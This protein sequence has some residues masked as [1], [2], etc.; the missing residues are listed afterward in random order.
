MLVLASRVGAGDGVAS[1]QG[2]GALVGTTSSFARG[3]SGDGSV[4]I[5]IATGSG[6]AFRWSAATGM[7]VLSPPKGFTAAVPDG[8]STDGSI[9]VGRAAQTTAGP[10]L[11]CKWVGGT[12]ISLGAAGSVPPGPTSSFAFDVS[13]N[14]LVVVGTSTTNF[15]SVSHR[16]FR[17][18][19]GQTPIAFGTLSGSPCE[20][21]LANAVTPDGA[22]IVGGNSV[23][24]ASAAQAFRR[25]DATLMVGLGVPPGANSSDAF[26]VSD[27]GNVI[28]CSCQVVGLG[29]YRWINGTGW[30][31]V[32]GIPPGVTFASIG[33]GCMSADGS[34]IVGIATTPS[35]STF[36]FI[37]DA[38]HGLRNLY[39]VLTSECGLDLGDWVLNASSLDFPSV[40]DDGRTISG[41]GRPTPTSPQ[42]AWVAHMGQPP[43]DSDA[44]GLLDSWETEGQGMDVNG[45]GTIDLDLYAL[46]ARPDRKD[47]FVEIDCLEGQTPTSLTP[48]VN[49]FANAP[50]INPGGPAGINLHLQIDDTDLP[51]STAW[52]LQNS[53]DIQVN[54]KDLWFG[55]AAQRTHPNTINILEAKRRV[56]RYCTYSH[57]SD[58]SYGGVAFVDNFIVAKFHHE[59]VPEHERATF[60]HELGHSLGLGHGGG[61]GINHKPNYISVMNYLYSLP[62]NAGDAWRLDYS[63]GSMGP[64]IENNIDESTMLA[65]L[66]GGNIGVLTYYGLAVCPATPCDAVQATS[67]T[68]RGYLIGAGPKDFNEDG[69]ITAG[70]CI[71]LN[72]FGSKSGLPDATVPSPCEV[73]N[74]HNDWM[75]L[76]YALDYQGSGAVAGGPPPDPPL[77]LT[78]AQIQQLH[79]I[80]PGPPCLP[81]INGSRSVD[82]DDLIAVILNWGACPQP[83]GICVGD[84]APMPV[85]GVVDVDDLIAVILAWGSCP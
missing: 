52:T 36:V 67:I 17:T 61:D 83:P 25:T 59:G 13:D 76:I 21:S 65:P 68:D 64:I 47:L 32:T 60:M 48:V 15:C 58:G 62:F 49:A 18:V 6:P 77:E 80:L 12:A 81:D 75:S 53:F 24:G 16:A 69:Q 66:D 29:L 78:I 56:Y 46:G 35:F 4:V 19:N 79:A 63:R 14:G 41:T 82:V 22:V 45:D 84:I 54:L 5:G 44:D 39:D 31:P 34:T 70:A 50:V 71:D 28:A 74:D 26:D 27:D 85:N 3:I 57:S 11:A 51:L 33:R 2:L 55:T 38:A 43:T 7:T 40:S 42:Q 23:P 9:I 73:L 10:F 30:V 72:Y 1:F 8:V 20:T 37:W